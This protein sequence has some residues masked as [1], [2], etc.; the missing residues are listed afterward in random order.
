MS[1]R[2]VTQV[3][4]IFFIYSVIRQSFSLSIQSK[5]LDPSYKTDLGFLDRFGRA[6][7]N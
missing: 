3:K 6:K 2:L 7:P 4:N 1:L 5:N